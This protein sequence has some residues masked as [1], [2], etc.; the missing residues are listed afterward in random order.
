[1][2]AKNTMLLISGLAFAAVLSM[3]GSNYLHRVHPEEQ[4]HV[5]GKLIEWTEIAGSRRRP[6]LRFTISGFSADLRIDPFLFRDAMASRVPADFQPGAVIDV[7]A[8]R[9]EIAN[10]SRPALAKDLRIVWIN[11]L[12]VNGRQAFELQAALR[13]QAKEELW[14]WVLLLA[15]LAFVVYSFV[16]WQRQRAR[17]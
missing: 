11:G 16:G 7:I 4:E 14:G 5:T 17:L 3:L 6:T 13:H 9:S 12:S 2:P 1:M 15:A 10:P 8:S